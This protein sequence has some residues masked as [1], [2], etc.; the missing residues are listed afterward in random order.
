MNS[1]HSPRAAFSPVSRRWFIGRLSIGAATLALGSRSYAQSGAKPRK[2][3]V[4]LAGLGSYSR[5]QLGP[6][7]KL[8]ENCEL[9]G[10]VIYGKADLVRDTD[11]VVEILARVST[12]ALDNPDDQTRDKIRKAVRGTAPKRTGIR[13]HPDKI[14][15]WDHHKLGGAY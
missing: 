9:R 11:Q 15:S 10:V 4:A 5:G 7:L 3:G 1:S 14:V 6:A 13:V 8:T 12:K 2:L